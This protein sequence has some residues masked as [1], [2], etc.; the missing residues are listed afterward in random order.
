MNL[1]GKSFNKNRTPQGRL[2]ASLFNFSPAQLQKI[3]EGFYTDVYFTRTR[4]VIDNFHKK[5]GD[6]DPNLI[7]NVFSRH[8]KGEAVLCGIDYAVRLIQACTRGPVELRALY[9]GD[10]IAPSETVLTIKGHLSD[11]TELETVYLGML[12]RGTKVATNTRAVVEVASKADVP[13][14]FFP[15]RFDLFSNQQLDG[16]AGNVVGALGGSTPAQQEWWGGK[17]LGTMPH[18]MIA[19]FKPGEIEG[20]WENATVEAT[21]WFARTFP[22]VN[23]ISLVDFEND[24]AE[25]SLKVATALEKE[26]LNLWGVRLDT[27]GTLVDDSIVRKNQWSVKSMTGVN[28]TLVHNVRETLDAQGFTRDKVKIVVSG[29]FTAEKTGKFIEERVPFDALGIGSSL[30]KGMIDFTADIVA[31]EKNGE[32]IHSGK[33]GRRLPDDLSRLELVE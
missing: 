21:L 11:F 14:L 5:Y 7:M 1:S 13:V 26:G 18:A 30:L 9:E 22:D 2:P 23:C 8:K 15:A 6:Y 32:I 16:Y 17:P 24:C 28:P 33:V 10:I 3:K 25:T 4:Q 20:R 29:G 27:S 19:F 12:A 31:Y